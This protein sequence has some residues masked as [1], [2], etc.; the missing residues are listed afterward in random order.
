MD[1]DSDGSGQ[2]N[3]ATEDGRA[4]RGVP[5]S[6]GVPAGPEAQAPEVKEPKGW[7]SRGYLPHLDQLSLHQS[8]TFRLADSIPKT[9]LEHLHHNLKHLPAEKQ[10]PAR[11]RKIEQWLD[12]GWGCCALRHPE[13]ATYVQNSFLHF[14]GDRYDLKA[15]CIMP[16]HVHLL[17]LPHTPLSEIIHGW[18]SFTSRWIL[19]QNERLSLQIPDPKQF[20]QRDYWDRFIRDGDH[21]QN[22]I[23]YIHKNPIKAGLCRTPESYPWSSADTLPGSAGVPADLSTPAAQPKEN[24]ENSEVSDPSS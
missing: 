22:V 21:Y 4:P 10:D 17:I 2:P 12:S 3:E 23:D 20:W 13:I 7:H 11:R 14:H 6:A 19:K 24:R 5:G 9:K 8:I 16:N 18:K 15:W 1:P